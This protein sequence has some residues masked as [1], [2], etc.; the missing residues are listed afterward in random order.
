MLK[1]NWWL[2]VFVALVLCCP[3][4]L[5]AEDSSADL[6]M[7]LQ[8][9]ETAGVREESPSA[10]AYR[11]RDVQGPVYIPRQ[12]T[13]PS[14]EDLPRHPLTLEETIDYGLAHNPLLMAAGQDVS[15]AGKQVRQAQAEFFPKVDTGYSVRH[16]SNQPFVN[17]GDTEI[18]TSNTTLNRWEIDLSQ[19]LFTG[20]AL[21]SRLRISRLE[22][23]VTKYRLEET[24]LN[25]IRDI[26]RT[27][28]QELLGEKLVEVAR[29]NVKSLE[30]YGRNAQAQFQ[31][32]LT[33]ENDVL[34]ADVALAQA[35]QQERTTEKQ[36][37]IV[38]SRLNQ[39]LGLDLDTP[40]DIVE[41]DIKPYPAPEFSGL[42]GIAEKQRPKIFHSDYL[43]KTTI[44]F[45]QV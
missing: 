13:G 45:P 18:P 29:D 20:F 17:F 32:G 35:R 21:T 25:V 24:R 39:L 19:P 7:G 26:R 12:R 14:P 28:F 43:R 23:E 31:Q 2:V 22:Q 40:V 5:R 9:N 27:F 44:A 37:V 16:F 15:A 8:S 3:V 38:R 4:S 11:E 41:G 34:K 36:L 30:V 10:D 42:L 33:A 6:S 1:E